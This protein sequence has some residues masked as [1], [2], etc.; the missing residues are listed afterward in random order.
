MGKGQA[1]FALGRNGSG[2]ANAQVVANN[3][4]RKDVEARLV[5]LH[6]LIGMAEAA[7]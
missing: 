4:G 7:A 6:R 1:Q 3:A 5:A 2:H